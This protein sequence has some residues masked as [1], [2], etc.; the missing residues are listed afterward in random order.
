MSFATQSDRSKF[1][2]D[3]IRIQ[4]DSLSRSL[5]LDLRPIG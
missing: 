5:D 3:F 4:V 2:C 1:L